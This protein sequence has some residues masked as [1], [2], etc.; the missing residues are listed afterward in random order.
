MPASIKN[1]P[2]LSTTKYH[3]GKFQGA[4]EHEGKDYPFLE[5]PGNI[6]VA[7]GMSSV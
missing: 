1:H 7:A 3:S 5:C 6:G 2:I 4:E